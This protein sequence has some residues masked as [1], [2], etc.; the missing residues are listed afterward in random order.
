MAAFGFGSRPHAGTGSAHT[1]RKLQSKLDTLDPTN[2]LAINDWL[3][4]FRGAAG[5]DLRVLFDG[6]HDSV[7]TL[8]DFRSVRPNFAGYSDST[9]Q[10]TFDDFVNRYSLLN[11]QLSSWLVQYVHWKREPELARLIRG[12]DSSPG[13]AELGDGVAMYNWLKSHASTKASDVQTKLTC[14]WAVL[15]SEAH[16]RM[17]GHAA[18]ICVFDDVTSCDAVIEKLHQVHDNYE[19]VPEQHAQPATVFLK[20]ALQLIGDEVPPLAEW[21]RRLAAEI[22]LKPEAYTSRTAWL[23]GDVTKLLRNLLPARNPLFCPVASSDDGSKGGGGRRRQP[24]RSDARQAVRHEGRP[25]THA[26][27]VAQLRHRGARG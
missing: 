21:A 17:A 1:S 26:A 20:V 13:W 6:K 8:D 11:D 22:V 2:R 23:D 24:Q 14:D 27:H 10:P 5:P 18:K 19:L 9:L 4:S 3:I 7:Q 16:A 15:F 25:Q 12:N